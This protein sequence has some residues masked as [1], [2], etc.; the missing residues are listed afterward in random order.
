MCVQ[1]IVVCHMNKWNGA[2]ERER[3]RESF[4][5][6][7]LIYFILFIFVS[8]FDVNL[9]SSFSVKFLDIL[10][11]YLIGINSFWKGMI[12]C[13]FSTTCYPYIPLVT[14]LNLTYRRQKYLM[15]WWT[16]LKSWTWHLTMIED[17]KHK[18]KYHILVVTHLKN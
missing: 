7:L 11:C 10:I 16:K 4:Y 6:I 1:I 2:K 13:C 3:E 8:W 18:E 12:F 14:I 15:I 9:L 17:L 5:Y